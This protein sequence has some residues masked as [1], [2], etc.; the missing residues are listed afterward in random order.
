MM[1]RKLNIFL[2]ILMLCNLILQYEVKAGKGYVLGES[3]GEGRILIGENNSDDAK[4]GMIDENNKIIL[5]VKYDLIGKF[6]EGLAVAVID[7][8]KFY[9]DKNGKDVL[10]L[11]YN[12][13]EDLENG[14]T[15]VRDDDLYGCIDREGK[16]VIPIKYDNIGEFVD[17]QAKAEREGKKVYVN[18][19]GDEIEKTPFIFKGKGYVHDFNNGVALVNDNLSKYGLENRYGYIDEK[20]KVITPFEYDYAEDFKDGLAIV[21]I[22]PDYYYI[23][24]KGKKISEGYANIKKFSEGMAAVGS[25]L[26]GWHYGYINKKG[27]KVI[28]LEYEEA[29]EFHEGLAAVGDE[30][31]YGYINKKGKKITKL[32]YDRADDFS[33]GK[34]A[35]KKGKKYGYIDKAGKEI[36]Q[37]K[38]D[39]AYE[40][41]N[42]IALVKKNGKYGYIDKKGKIVIPLVYK[43]MY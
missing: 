21:H 28:P 41:K 25:G 40:F 42:G 3:L 7:N 4:V 26:M 9:I 32:K 34:A 24:T 35:V 8:K 33:E 43:G 13:V 27:K 12:Y 17:G 2:V 10:E 5:E 14:L 1:K 23:N 22:W 15:L 30:G 36:I 16:E 20:G 19:K 6:Y 39:E 18:Y 29:G 38:Y 11:K 31:K 37:M